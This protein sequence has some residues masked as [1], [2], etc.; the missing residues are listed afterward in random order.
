MRDHEVQAPEHPMEEEDH[1]ML[2]RSAYQQLLSRLSEGSRDFWDRPDGDWGARGR[3]EPLGDAE[4]ARRADANS[5]YV[6][7][8]KALRRDELDNARAWFAAAA[9]AEHPGAAFRSALTAARSASREDISALHSLLRN[10]PDNRETEVRRWLRVAAHWGHGDA[11]HLLGTPP[12]SGEMTPGAA[13]QGAGGGEVAGAGRPARVEDTEFYDELHTFLHACGSGEGPEPGREGRAEPARSEETERPREAGVP[14]GVLAKRAGALPNRSA[15]P[16]EPAHRIQRAPSDG[17]LLFVLVALCAEGS[18]VASGSRARRTPQEPAPFGEQAHQRWPVV[19]RPRAH[20]REY[21][22]EWRVESLPAVV[23]SPAASLRM[24][25]VELPARDEVGGK[26]WLV[27]GRLVHVTTAGRADTA[28]QRYADAWQAV[29]AREPVLWAA[30]EPRR[31]GARPP[32]AWLVLMGD[33]SAVEAVDP[34]RVPGAVAGPG[35]HGCVS[36]DALER[37]RPADLWPVPA[38]SGVLAR[39]RHAVQAAGAAV[40]RWCA[41]FP[42]GEPDGWVVLAPVGWP[43]LERAVGARGDADHGG[44]GSRSDGRLPQTRTRPNS[45]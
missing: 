14:G 24:A 8:T 35:E 30:G 1:A 45:P 37:L 20:W 17:Q 41:D 5:A 13:G 3:E 28:G 11:R 7:G 38:S 26:A 12:Q 31:G 27:L 43:E 19:R 34:G 4:A 32:R 36:F 33:G 6:I 21:L 39:L 23:A 44:A 9:D 15:A 40:H 25:E 29:W 16:L 22:R 42:A 10:S 18:R 2:T